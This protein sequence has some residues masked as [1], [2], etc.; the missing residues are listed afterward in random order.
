MNILL[1]TLIRKLRIVLLYFPV[2]MIIQ[3]GTT[4]PQTTTLIDFGANNVSN[5][6]GMAG[7]NTVLLGGVMSYTDAG[8]D[9]V[10]LSSG[11]EEFSDNMGVKGVPRQFRKGERIV[12]T[13][14]NNSGETIPFTSRVSFTDEDQPESGTSNGNWYT[15]RQ[16][17]DYRVTFSE[18]Q[19]YATIKTVFNITD[20][21]VHKTDSIYSVVNINLSILWNPNT[22]KEFLVCD[23]IEL[24]NDAD[25]S[26]PQKPA[27]LTASTLSDTK[28]RLNWQPATDNIGVV[29][30]YIYMNGQIEGYSRT[31]S[32]TAVFLEP[33]KTY[34]FSVTALDGCGNESV[35]SDP[36]IANTNSYLGVPNLV[37][38]A[39]VVYLGAFRLPDYF[40][41]AGEGIAYNRDGDGGETGTGAQD[42]YKGSLY[43]TNL[44]QME[45]GMVAEF[46]IPAPVI[47]AA[48]NLEELN[49][50]AII[51][52]PVNIRPASVNSW[53][54]VDIWRTGLTYIPQE[55]RLYSSWG[56]HYQVGGEKTASISCCDATDLSGSIKHGAWFVGNPN[57]PPVDA[58]LNEYLFSLPQTWANVN[59]NG[60]ALV[61][62]RC[63]DGG[64]SGLGPTLYAVNLVG[65]NT[66]LAPGAQLDF[67]TLLKY[68]SVEGTNEYEFP[69]SIDGYKLCDAW[70]D[71]SWVSA[72]SQS[73][74]LFAGVKGLGNNWYGY[75]GENMRHDWVI[76][77]T[78][79]PDFYNTDPDGKGWKA[80]VYQPMAILYNPADLASVANGSMNSFQPQPYAAIRFD[81][82]I[83][84]GTSRTICSESYDN[85]NKLLYVTEF[86]APSDGRL[87]I[88][89][90]R[91]NETTPVQN[92]NLS[93]TISYANSSS[94]PLNNVKVLLRNSSGSS[95]DSTF[96]DSNGN[97]LFYGLAPGL[98]RVA[99]NCG[100][101]WGGANAT[102]A[103]AILRFSVGLINLDSLQRKAADVNNNGDISS[104]DALLVARRT[105]GLSNSFP[106]GD[107]VFENPLINILNNN[108][109]Q[110]IRGLCVGDVNGSYTPVLLKN[111]K[112]INIKYEK[113]ILA[114]DK[115]VVL[116][117]LKVDCNV[118]FGAMSLFVSY[119]ENLIQFLDVESKADG[120]VFNC[121]NG[122]FS[123]AWQNII[124]MKLNSGDQVVVLK[125]KIKETLKSN[126]VKLDLL[127]QSEFSDASG[128]VISDIG[129]LIPVLAGNVPREFI[130][131]NNYPNP[132]N[133][134]TVISY[135]LPVESRVKIT[136]YNVLGQV[137]QEPVNSIKQA[138]TYDAAFDGSV[139]S[140]GVYFYEINAKAINGSE[141]FYSVK[142]AVLQK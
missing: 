60:R 77:D 132:F 6:F 127:P 106:A 38:P 116:L 87:I 112:I 22:L 123:L 130:L 75:Q 109:T 66:P 71:A 122:L 68:G 119:P 9:G 65:S 82:S 62:G 134:A 27:G 49:E 11:F 86:G 64:L 47:S 91:I 95:V 37:S 78:P 100:K 107:W 98:Y 45:Q 15:M 5:T 108:V 70:R 139:L 142:K 34:T 128:R 129:L 35:R 131:K 81:T 104:V 13:W 140:S 73:A 125:F 69:N 41:Y 29:E 124:P 120:F 7:W 30:Y 20:L 12:A 92:F 4:W 44:N 121:N 93:G 138:G 14:Y 57:Q 19:P 133:P 33:S 2:L 83:F 137:V 80:N 25:I 118:T 56:Y 115:D 76:L 39:G 126:N 63:R 28:I 46:S 16:F 79:Y 135:S 110:D 74:V 89:V 40:S 88:H 23:K 61:T 84:W 48:K 101:Q 36:V 52:N 53:P 103:L 96:S 136:I 55:K 97:Y 90:W 114:G 17:N 54:Y 99:V 32:F 51:L 94:T 102:D 26:A 141:T 18:I 1:F 113:E 43:V 59:T 24:M 111:K 21:G 58:M 50:A 8:P 42:G 3:S 85:E 10:I 72:G 67:T 105:V 117:P 31:N